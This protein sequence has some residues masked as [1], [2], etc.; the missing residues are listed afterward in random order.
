MSVLSF[1]SNLFGWSENR[2][3]Q[4][5]TITSTEN[6][7]TSWREWFTSFSF[8]RKRKYKGFHWR[9]PI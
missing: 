4:K 5:T 6:H 1:V 9:R 2:I 8:L 3:P 7:I